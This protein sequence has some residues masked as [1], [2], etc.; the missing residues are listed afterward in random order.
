MTDRFRALGILKN[1]YG[2]SDI[3]IGLNFFGKSNLWAEL[4]KPDE[5]FDY[6][7]YK[8]PDYILGKEVPET[9]TQNL[10]KLTL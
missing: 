2:E 4:P 5:I 7:K 10:I 1:R 6:E 8:T 3:E 9:N